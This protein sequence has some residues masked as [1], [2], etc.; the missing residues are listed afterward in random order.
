MAQQ[1][2]DNKTADIF[3]LDQAREDLV[4]AR[5]HHLVKV[6]AYIRDDAKA[7]KKT[8]GAERVEKFREKQKA[9]GLV[10]VAIPKE[11]AE[12]VKATEGGFAAWLEAQKPAPVEKIVN[13]PGPERIVIQE[14][15]VEVF[16][17]EPLGSDEYRA[18]EIGQKVQKLTGWR[19]SLVNF[20]AGLQP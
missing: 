8:A 17:K 3:D 4:L 1:P 14:K 6:Q 16:V 19:R 15:P 20:L 9:A 11:V 18:L 5:D 10:S 12:A 7:A 2:D 13:V